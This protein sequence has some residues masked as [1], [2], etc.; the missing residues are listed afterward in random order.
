MSIPRTQTIDALRCWTIFRGDFIFRV[1]LAASA[2]QCYARLFYL[3]ADSYTFDDVFSR[4]DEPA[5][6]RRVRGDL[7]DALQTFGSGHSKPSQTVERC[8]DALISHVWHD[9][10][11]EALKLAGKILIRFSL[12][13]E[14]EVLT[15]LPVNHKHSF[16]SRFYRGRLAFELHDALQKGDF[17]NV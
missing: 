14:F 4:E 17:P 3:R 12:S 5:L 15:W 13:E 2:S 9:R 7:P 16:D 8:Y 1:Q 10:V 6:G 11:A